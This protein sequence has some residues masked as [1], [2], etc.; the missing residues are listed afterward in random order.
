MSLYDELPENGYI[1]KLLIGIDEAFVE[2][3]LSTK[4][5]YETAKDKEE[6]RFSR[7]KLTNLFWELYGMV[8]KVIGPEMSMA[9]RLFLRYGLTDLRNLSP[10]DQKFILN[11]PSAPVDYENETIFYADEWL[12]G[13]SMG[14]IKA[15]AGDET[16]GGGAKTKAPE[17]HEITAKQEKYVATISVEKGRYYSFKQSRDESIERIIQCASHLKEEI[18]DVEMGY[19][20]PDNT[21]LK[22]LDEIVFQ[23]KEIKKYNKEMLAC[24]RTMF[25][26]Q[27]TLDDIRE[28]EAEAS[29]RSSG[30]GDVSY[31]APTNREGVASEVL[32][33]R[34]MAKM[35][36]GR[37]GNAFPF[38]T[39]GFMPRETKDYLFREMVKNK[40]N[41]WLTLDPQAFTR[42]Y[43]GEEMHIMPYMILVPGY[44]ATGS[45]WEP[46]DSNNKQFGRGRITLPIFTKSPDLSLLTAIGDIRWQA[47]KEMA[48]YYWMEEGLTGNY[49]E[50]SLAAKLKG[51]LRLM[52]IS[53]Y[54]TWMAKETQ[55]VQKLEQDCRYVFWRYVPLPDENKENLSKK[56]YYYNQL[57]EKEQVWRRS[58]K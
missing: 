45:C 43:K 13:I 37:Q 2:R 16:G 54:L 24:A 41:K 4:K 9:K 42:I 44:G 3:F 35:T 56:G 55:G 26:A 17:A 34:Q 38:L 14:K 32:N 25:K 20:I 46:L 28:Q 30:E 6:K 51:D 22:S 53:D 48:S 40:L 8:A 27:Q 31:G 29:G 11:Q 15:S 23:H 10:E 52:F 5:D 50:Y 58:G 36:V 7:D 57:W 18:E 47:A 39:S 33:I 12:Q 49:Y 21:Q 19:V 1:K